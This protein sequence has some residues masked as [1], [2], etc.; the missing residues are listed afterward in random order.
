[1]KMKDN[2]YSHSTQIPIID[3]FIGESMNLEVVLMDE[4]IL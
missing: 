4:L 1:M 2:Y 3:K